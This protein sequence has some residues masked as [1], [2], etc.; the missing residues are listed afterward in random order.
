MP[1]TTDMN[2]TAEMAEYD[3]VIV[4]QLGRTAFC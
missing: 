3:V 4:D 1:N 2:G